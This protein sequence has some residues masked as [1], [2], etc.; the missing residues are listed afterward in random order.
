[1]RT[2]TLLTIALFAAFVPATA[3]DLQMRMR[4]GTSM[5]GTAARTSLE[6]GTT[7]SIKGNQVRIDQEV[8]AD[9]GGMDASVIMDDSAGSAIMLLHSN[10]TYLNM[11]GVRA[12]LK[13]TTDSV[14]AAMAIPDTGRTVVTGETAT[15]A[16]Y[17]T[18]RQV[19]IVEAPGGMPNISSRPVLIIHESWVTRDPALVAAYRDFAERAAA[20]ATA[21]GP[22]ASLVDANSNE[23][24][25]RMRIIVIDASKK[26][27]DPVA[28]L[29]QPDLPVLMRTAMEVVEVKLGPLPDSLFTV[30]SDYQPRKQP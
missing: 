21:S 13:T 12:S 6:H 24:P 19:K 7:L 18:E 9:M 17:L 4:M 28:L 2:P 16:G 23:V 8:G 29:N 3:Q 10:K 14:K 30:P 11:G 22:G 20:F 26:S 27:A 5:A 15:I 1:M 25:M